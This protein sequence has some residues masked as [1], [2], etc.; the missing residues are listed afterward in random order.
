[1]SNTPSTLRYIA[2][3]EWVRQEADGTV[4]IGITDHAQNALGDLVYVELP[5]VGRVVAQDES[6]PVVESVKAA[7]DVYSPLSG[8]ILSI[9][10]ALADSPELINQEPYQAGW[11]WTMRLSN[12]S[13]LDGLLDAAGYEATL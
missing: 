1:M 11:L 8:E 4:T 7:S 10:E 9:N 3:H 13:E 2:S 12:A 6:V 5:A